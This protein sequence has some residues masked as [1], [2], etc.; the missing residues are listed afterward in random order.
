MITS[1]DIAVWTISGFLALGVGGSRYLK[2]KSR[3]DLVRQ[4]AAMDAEKRKKMLD[5]L[6]PAMAMEIRQELLERFRMMT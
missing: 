4:F 6:P 1:T 2:A 3:N 5:R